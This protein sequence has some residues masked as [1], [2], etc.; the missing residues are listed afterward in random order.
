[1]D[2]RVITFILA[3]GR[4]ERLHP[5]T[6]DRAK[7]AVPFGGIYRIIDITLSNCINSGLR[8]I[9]TLI[10]YKS[11]SLQ[12][13]MRQ[14]WNIFN[15]ELGEYIDVIPAQQRIGSNW[16]QGTADAIYQ[17]IY[18]IEQEKPDEILILAG[19]HIYK[20]NYRSMIDFHRQSNAD[21]TVGVVE[22]GKETSP[23]FG[24]I[25]TD[26]SKRVLGFQEKPKEPKCIPGKPDMIYASMGIYVFN[27]ES[28]EEEV[29]EDAAKNTT[30]DFGKDIIPQMIKKKKRVFSYNFKD[31]N[32][33][34]A[35][36][37]RD[38]G[39]LDA[40][41]E[42]NMDLIQVSPVFNLYDKEWPIRTCQEQC[43]AAKTV[44]AGDENPER[45]GL[46]LDSIISGGCIVSGGRVQRSILSPNVRIN[47]Y[48]E[49][50]DS[51]LMDGV[52]VGR[53]AKIRRAIIDKDVNI[54]PS[55]VIGYNLKDD[56]KR[57][58]ISES[59]IVVV[60]KGTQI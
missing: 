50:Y 40:Y 32:K 34:E 12:R 54:P 60:A 23:N 30:H 14:G 39:T 51:I 19:D 37:W 43:P 36:Y 10:Q 53:Y 24:V 42:A 20:M 44:F 47:S 8:K 56:K 9:H 48:S 15:S 7:P 28:L 2:K 1:M 17:N 35:L 55:T 45:I 59:G 33:K 52:N 3:G 22:L 49:I 21:M 27:R 26:E 38:I 16:Y 57:F 41:Y 46:V 11:I 18:T 25:Q 5:L 29:A 6:K 31:E 4:G 13:H 58:T